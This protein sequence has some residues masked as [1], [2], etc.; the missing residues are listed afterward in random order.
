MIIK[1]SKIN[2]LIEYFSLFLVISFILHHNIKVVIT[3]IILSI[4]AINKELINKFIRF[5][6]DESEYR[7][8]GC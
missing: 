5:H 3:G 7:N 8:K 1:E 2:Q 4:Y 6:I